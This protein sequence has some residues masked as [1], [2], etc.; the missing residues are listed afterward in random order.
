M[1]LTFAALFF[2][3]SSCGPAID[4]QPEDP[5]AVGQPPDLDPPSW[6]DTPAER[7]E[8]QLVAARHRAAL[9]ALRDAESR[10][11]VGLG[12]AD[13]DAS[14]FQHRADIASVTLLVD[15]IP[16]GVA[17][18][19]REL[20]GVTITF[21]PVS[22]L[23]ESWLDRAIECHLARDA[24]AGHDMPEM[25]D[26]PLV[27]AGASARVSDTDR[28]LVVEIRGADAAAA[29]EIARR[30]SRLLPTP[31]PSVVTP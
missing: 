24:A 31:P 25:P 4:A 9:P 28:G 17:A 11:C 18:P 21:R 3:A 16:E 30:A 2:V 23:T 26:C 20:Q 1:R 29:E 22:G 19:V 27:P 14:P 13:R 15:T 6:S 7:A 12:D 5:G 8:A 10:A